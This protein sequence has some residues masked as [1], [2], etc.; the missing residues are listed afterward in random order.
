MSHFLPDYGFTK[1][2]GTLAMQ[3]IAGHADPKKLQVVNLHPGIIYAA[4]WKGA[5]VQPT[6]L[7]FD[8]GE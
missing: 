3:L 8:D 7:P 5:G 4:G 6:Q 2:A 1:N